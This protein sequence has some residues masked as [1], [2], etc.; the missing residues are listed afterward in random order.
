VQPELF[1]PRHVSLQHRRLQHSPVERVYA[2]HWLALNNRHSWLNHGYTQLEWILCPD[3]QRLPPPVSQRDAHVAASVI[4]WLGTAC[5][6]GFIAA[7]ERGAK[8]ATEFERLREA[9]KWKLIGTGWQAATADERE[10]ARLIA[11]ELKGLDDESQVDVI[12]GALAEARLG[13]FR[14]Y[15][16]ELNPR[17]VRVR[18]TLGEET[19]R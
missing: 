14:P 9:F 6:L 18:Q 3:S 12:A 4:Q 19:T 2:S 7:A 11:H 10:R 5:G 15:P 17:L 16:T 13:E 1:E 8:I